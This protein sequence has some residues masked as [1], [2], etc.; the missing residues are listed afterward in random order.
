MLVKSKARFIRLVPNKVRQ[1]LDLIRDKDVDEAL[2]ILNFVK[3]RPKHQIF[4]VLKSALASAKQKGFQEKQ[5]YIS[6]ATC[7]NGPMWKRYKAA[8]FGRATR[9][10]KRTSHITIELD[11]KT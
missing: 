5:L 1:V 10:R 3:K 8:P 4:K 6:K 11:L 2:T 7:D 9:I